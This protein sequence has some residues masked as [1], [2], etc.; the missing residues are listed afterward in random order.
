MDEAPKKVGRP[1]GPIKYSATEKII[2]HIE[3]LSSLGETNI[4]TEHALAKQFNVSRTTVR[5]A[6]K[7]LEKDGRAKVVPGKGWTTTEQE[8]HF[9]LKLTVLATGYLSEHIF[10]YLLNLKDDLNLKIN[11][12]PLFD[13]EKVSYE[14]EQCDVFLALDGT[15]LDELLTFNSPKVILLSQH[16]CPR[17]GFYSW[18]NASSMVQL[19]EQ[20]A[21]SGH[22]AIHYVWS[23]E[24]A[25]KNYAFRER[26]LGLEYGCHQSEISLSHTPIKLFEVLL[27]EN[28]ERLISTIK[29]SKQNFQKIAIVNHIYGQAWSVAHI[30]RGIDLEPGV[31][32]S[33]VA[34]G[35]PDG[36]TNSQGFR[37]QDISRIEEDWQELL[38]NCIIDLRNLLLDGSPPY[39]MRKLMLAPVIETES[40][41]S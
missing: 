24:L 8:Q 21:Y 41:I 12:L 17:V 4:P 32:Y 31:D 26:F 37:F 3:Q 14:L 35:S 29:K 34:Y 33:L 15:Y 7:R 10:G 9:V 23:K 25:E 18:D 13:R 30:L 36:F 22:D 2:S 16:I 40:I 27:P 28:V 1:R 20:L 19:T 5:G 11:F 38:K 6:L 39:H